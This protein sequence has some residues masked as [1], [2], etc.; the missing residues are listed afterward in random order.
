MAPARVPNAAVWDALRSWIDSHEA[1]ERAN[2]VSA[3]TSAQVEVISNL[4]K[5]EEKPDADGRNYVVELNR[6][7]TLGLVKWSS[8][9][10]ADTLRFLRAFA[11]TARRFSRLF[12]RGPYTSGST[13]RGWSMARVLQAV[14][15]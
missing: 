14:M 5:V 7:M 6:E 10:L 2:G 13:W 8:Q 9:S 3:I 4:I 11:E 15:V 12:K 1:Q